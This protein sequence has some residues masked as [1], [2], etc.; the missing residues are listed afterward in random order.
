M[1]VAASLPCAQAGRELRRRLSRNRRD[2]TTMSAAT[3]TPV[4]PCT[5]VGAGRVGAA[6]ERMGDGK[7]VVRGQAA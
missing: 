4:T 3:T 1:L 2:V 5:I 6:L 7:D